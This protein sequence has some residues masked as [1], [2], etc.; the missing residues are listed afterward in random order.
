M[1]NKDVDYFAGDVD[2][3]Y[4]GCVDN[5]G[6]IEFKDGRIEIAYF[7]NW[8]GDERNEFTISLWYLWIDPYTNYV[9]VK[10]VFFKQCLLFLD[11]YSAGVDFGRTERA[12]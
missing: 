2:L 11:H 6:C 12:K 3:H 1:V 7:N 4:S 10:Y 8:F 5:R 9:Q